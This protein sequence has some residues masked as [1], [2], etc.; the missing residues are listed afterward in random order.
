[1][2]LPVRWV[3]AASSGSD[4]RMSW[5]LKCPWCDW[6]VYVGDRGMHGNDMGAGF[7]A[8]KLGEEHAIEVHHRTWR[9][10]LKESR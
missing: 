8:A 2:A 3:S 4:E 10:F 7:E 9:E 5:L 1:M 6:S